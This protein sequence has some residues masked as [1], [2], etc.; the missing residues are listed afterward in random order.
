M[1]TNLFN[2]VF[3]ALIFF[4]VLFYSFW[5]GVDLQRGDTKEVI[6]DVVLLAFWIFGL[7]FFVAMQRQTD[8]LDREFED[9]K[10]KLDDSLND[11]LG[12]LAE[13]HSEPKYDNPKHQKLSDTFDKIFKDVV[14]DKTPTSKDLATVRSKFTKA[15]GHDV[16]LE[17]HPLGLSVKIAK[18]PIAKKKSAAKKPVTKKKGTK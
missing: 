18:E 6:V 8:K 17:S 13:A 14:G 10:R 9:S 5:L 12:H 16:K 4:L 15:T 1:K 7:I 2:K 3:I 11:L